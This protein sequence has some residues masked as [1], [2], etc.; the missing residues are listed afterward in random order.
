MAAR[1]KIV[2]S[3]RVPL[4]LAVRLTRPRFNKFR[5]IPALIHHIASVPLLRL[6]SENFQPRAFQCVHRQQVAGE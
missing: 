2:L 4:A 5:L 6:T 3:L 1:I